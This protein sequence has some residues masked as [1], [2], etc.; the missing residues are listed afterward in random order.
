MII[1]E[2]MWGPQGRASAEANGIALTE[3][4]EALHSPTSLNV[5]VFGDTALYVV[6]L[7]KSDRVVFVIA[8]RQT[9]TSIFEIVFA[10]L[11][12][13]REIQVWKEKTQ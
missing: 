4:I 9:K 1:P 6:G 5:L 13:A 12:N 10:R 2:F 11:A 8:D 7:A 3:V